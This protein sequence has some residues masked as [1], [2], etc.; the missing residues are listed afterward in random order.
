MSQTTANNPEG[1]SADALSAFAS[2]ASGEPTVAGAPNSVD[3]FTSSVDLHADSDNTNSEAEASSTDSDEDMGSDQDTVDIAGVADIEDV[4]DAE[5]IVD[6]ESTDAEAEGFNGEKDLLVELVEAQAERDAYRNDLLR[7]TSEFTNFRKQTTKRNEE[8]VAQAAS[9]LVVSLLPVLDAFE[10]AVS[11]GVDGIDALQTQML[12]VLQNGGL[13][14]VGVEGEIF[15]PTRHEAV[16][17]EASEDDDG[18]PT[19]VVAVL[20]TGYA[21]QSK[22]LRPAMVKVKG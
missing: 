16:V 14:I 20:R 3:G 11:Q 12:G 21:W 10:A 19:Q 6:G 17:H 7:V 8:I 13:S 2:A 15:D 18:S 9:K 22:I 5:V 4:V 1:G